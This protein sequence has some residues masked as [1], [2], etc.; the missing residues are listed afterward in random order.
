VVGTGT[1]SL[2]DASTP[3][4]A[5]ADGNLNQLQTSLS[6]L[7]LPISVADSNGYTL[8]QAAA[9]YG[10]VAIVQ[11]LF[12]QAKARAGDST[13]SGLL[14]AVDA[15]GDSALHY[16]STVAVAE[17]LIQH[18]ISTQIQNAAGLTPLQAKQQELQ[19]LQDDEDGEGFDEDDEDVIQLQRLVTHLSSLQNEPQGGQG[20]S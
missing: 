13:L 4:V 17:L 1:A 19:E 20:H 12:Q 14:Q 16:A 15:D 8:L 5:A 11:W 18:G 3:W 7:N 9:S 2:V 6:M 10:Q